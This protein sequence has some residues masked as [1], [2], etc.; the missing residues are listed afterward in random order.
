MDLR[1]IS[2]KFK[3]LKYKIFF[4]IKYIIQN[5]N[6]FNKIKMFLLKFNCE[7]MLLNQDTFPWKKRFIFLQNTNALIGLNNLQNYNQIL[8][9]L[10]LNSNI[11]IIG[12]MLNSIIFSKK[13]FNIK[14]TNKIN[15]LYLLHQYIYN[16]VYQLNRQKLIIYIKL[17]KILQIHGNN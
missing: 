12:V 6:D 9:S 11:F 7:F 13:D 14:N 2:F 17:S 10:N 16:F 15:I 1:K 3:L 8:N 4:L 5:T